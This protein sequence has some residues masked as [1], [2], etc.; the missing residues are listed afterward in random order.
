MRLN[1]TWIIIY[2][3]GILLSAILTSSGTAIQSSTA[4][5][6]LLF[7]FFFYQN[8]KADLIRTDF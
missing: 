3:H 4:S 2:I 7:F 8:I 1:S 6:F 5:L